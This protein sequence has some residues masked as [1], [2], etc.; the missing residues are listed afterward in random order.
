MD[1]SNDVRLVGFDPDQKGNSAAMSFDY[2]SDASLE[3]YLFGPLSARPHMTLS[4]PK[5][6]PESQPDYVY[7]TLYI[8]SQATGKRLATVTWNKEIGDWVIQ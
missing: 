7:T 1:F 6:P 8:L 2:N 5:Q 4:L 3:R